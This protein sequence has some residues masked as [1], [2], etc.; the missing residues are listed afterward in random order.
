MDGM[1]HACR[2]YTVAIA[3]TKL[4][5]RGALTLLQSRTCLCKERS[6]ELKK[7]ATVSLIKLLT[8]G[9]DIAQGSVDPSFGPGLPSQYPKSFDLEHCMIP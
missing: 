2:K 8:E 7:A 4:H 3:V 1:M 9:G 6:E 5:R